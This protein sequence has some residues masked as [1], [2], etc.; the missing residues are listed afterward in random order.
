MWENVPPSPH[1]PYPNPDKNLD[2]PVFLGSQIRVFTIAKRQLGFLV[3]PKVPCK[4]WS[5][6][7]DVLDKVPDKTFL[8]TKKYW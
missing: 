2:K 4:H 1:Y 5:D 7:A 3:T 8:S 6:C